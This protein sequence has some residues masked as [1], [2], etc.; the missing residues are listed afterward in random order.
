MN[1][2]KEKHTLRDCAYWNL[3]G[4]I[5]LLLA[6]FAIAQYSMK[7][8]F[9][10]IIVFA[11][12]F[13]LL[14]YK[15]FCTH[16][17]HYCNDTPTTNCMFLWFVPKFFKKNPKPLKSVDIVMLIL[18]FSITIF[19]PIYWLIQSWQLC[20]V[21]FLS[22]VVLALTIKRYECCRCI[23][24]NCPANTVEEDIKKEFINKPV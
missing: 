16:C 8:V 3:F 24:F 7:W 20:I 10:Y 13:L 9:V 12:H 21:Y 17:P 15:F 22:W 11:G 18:G 23:Y 19:F 6:S 4:L 2:L 5:P 14:E 1:T